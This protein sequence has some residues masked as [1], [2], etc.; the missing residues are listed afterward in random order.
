MD[1]YRYVVH[2]IILLLCSW[3]DN[4]METKMFAYVLCSENRYRDAQSLEGYRDGK[5]NAK[6]KT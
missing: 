6:V 5:E 4:I 3:K 1:E 2:I